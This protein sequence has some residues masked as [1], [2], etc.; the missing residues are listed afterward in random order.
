[1]PLSASQVSILRALADTLL[2][3]IGPGD[4]AG[5]ELVPAGVDEIL[6]AMKPADTRRV[7]ALLTVFDLAAV[8]RFGRPFSKLGPEQRTRYVTGWMTSRIALQ[9][10]IYRALRG[11]C[12]TAYYQNPRSWPSIGYDGPLVGRR[13]SPDVLGAAS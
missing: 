2:P 12:M 11:L 8:L 1:M 13:P 10:T 5:G 7:G 9:R 3:S 4:P 6:A